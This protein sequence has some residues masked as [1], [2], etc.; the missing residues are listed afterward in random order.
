M[1]LFVFFII[2][3]LF[4]FIIRS[5]LL[6]TK[7]G[8]NP[9]TFNKT[10][11]AHGFNGKVFTAITF[12]ELIVV[13]IYAFKIE[14]YKYLLPFWYIENETLSKRDASIVI[15]IVINFFVGL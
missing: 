8:I 14:W 11:D 6:K 3:F 13:G 9:F 15:I 2:Y 7:T 10:D 5:I 12:I 4:V 1:L